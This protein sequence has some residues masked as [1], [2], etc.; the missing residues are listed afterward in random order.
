MSQKRNN[1]I[2]LCKC[3]CN[4]RVKL[5]NK[6]MLGHNG[7]RKGLTKE[8][9][10]SIAAMA[11]KRRGRTKKNHP[12]VAAMAEKLKGRTKENNSGIAITAT[13]LKGRTKETHLYLAIRAGKLKGRTIE[14]HSSIARMAK[15]K[16]GR[17]K[18]TH[19]YLTTIS[20]KV[21]ET[22]T[23]RTKETHSYIASRAEKMIGRLA[24]SNNPNWKGGITFESYC[25]IWTDKEYKEDIKKRDNYQCQN[26]DCWNKN[27]IDLM[28]HH[29]D[30]NKKECSP[31]NLIT[32][33]RS[34]NARANF[35]RDYWQQTYQAIWR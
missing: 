21:S 24:G 30:Y 31:S 17:S 10:F 33:C 11:E 35:N 22:L 18:K 28:I 27:S 16:R 2:G 4:R 23:G 13:K 20:K 14:T 5:G 25:E 8:N 29:I 34:C 1:K 12:G 7:N 15:T 32:L 26:S 6:F 3:G 19:S 9:D